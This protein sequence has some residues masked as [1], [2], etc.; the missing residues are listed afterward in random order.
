MR[1]PFA[2]VV[3]AA[4]LISA[5]TPAAAQTAADKAD[6]RCV[7]A[8]VL[9]GRD[10]KATAEARQGTFYYLGKMDGR[11]ATPKLEGLMAIE[12]RTLNTPALVQAE[13]TRCGGELTRRGSALAAMFQR[14][15]AAAKA[16]QPAAPAAAAPAPAKK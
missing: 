4:T 5:G 14:L 1:F 11:G 9:A 12:A 6:T 8:L 3:G 7:L 16:A 2:A 13:L 15:Q 10:P